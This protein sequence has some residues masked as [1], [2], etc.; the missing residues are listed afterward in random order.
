MMLRRL[1][2]L[3]GIA[4]AFAACLAGPVRGEVKAASPDA[5]Q[6]L[7]AERVAAPPS[8]VYQAI[9]QIGRWWSGEHTY[10]G[11]A[12]NLSFALQAGACFCERWQD[13]AV[14]HGRAV[15]LMRDQAVR[16]SAA[17]GPLQNKAVNGVLTFLLKAEEGGTSL[18]VGYRVNGSSVSAL[19]KDA[20]AVD[21]VLAT[22][23]QR[24]KSYVET[25]KPAR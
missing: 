8:A 15:L 4:L 11:D 10:S 6:L 7:F 13:N 1:R 18:T 2:T 22:Q 20:A 12:A 17:L 19:D 5:F 24:L 14:E 23:V 25:G 21:G 9:G 3:A 16:L